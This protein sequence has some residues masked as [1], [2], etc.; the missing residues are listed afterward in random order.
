MSNKKVRNGLNSKD[1]NK[2]DVGMIMADA[3]SLIDP[4]NDPVIV[5]IGS[6]GGRD[7]VTMYNHLNGQG[8]FI[9]VDYDHVR[10]E[11]AVENFQDRFLIVEKEA[12]IQQA[13]D[14]GKISFLSKDTLSLELPDHMKAD[15]MFSMAVAMFVEP[16]KIEAYAR[17]TLQNMKAGAHLLH[18]H[19]DW[20]P[21]VNDPTKQ[22]YP[23]GY[24]RYNESQIKHVFEQHGAA[25]V[26]SK[27]TQDAAGRGFDWYVMDIVKPS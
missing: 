7:I 23:S 25:V 10:A 5:D 20:R 1:H 15:F 26:S 12:G 6:G 16:K 13:I 22:R 14:H 17:T 11:D 24:N 2:I 3:F 19:S 8:T 27:T 21:A 9:A 18:I 4:L